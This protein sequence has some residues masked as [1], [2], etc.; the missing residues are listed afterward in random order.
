[1]PDIL[2]VP[3]VRVRKPRP[4]SPCPPCT[5]KLVVVTSRIFAVGRAFVD[6]QRPM[7]VG[8]ARAAECVVGRAGECDAS[9]GRV[10][11]G[12]EIKHAVVDQVVADRKMCASLLSPLVADWNVPLVAIVTEVPTV[13]VR[14]VVNFVSQHGAPAARPDRDDSELPPPYQS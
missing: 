1:M 5:V 9:A 11:A 12:A 3:L 13:S 10:G 2:N 8:R 6:G 14:A 4:R 7:S